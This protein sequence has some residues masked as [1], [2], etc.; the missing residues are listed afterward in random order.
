MGLYNK[1]LKCRWEDARRSSLESDKQIVISFERTSVDKAVE[2]EQFQIF[3]FQDQF[4]TF[5][6]YDLPE[7]T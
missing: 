4:I 2:T 5:Y 1:Y 6:L 7:L 3:L